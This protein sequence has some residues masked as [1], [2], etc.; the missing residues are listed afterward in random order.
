MALNVDMDQP[1]GLSSDHVREYIED[2]LDALA[3]LAGASGQRRLAV[4]L[5]TAALEA[6]RGPETPL[7]SR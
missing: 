2:M 4:T 5:Q 7:K 6:A 3:K 1:V